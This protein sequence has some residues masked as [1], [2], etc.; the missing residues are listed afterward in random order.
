M[1]VGSSGSPRREPRRGPSSV[2]LLAK[3]SANCWRLRAGQGGRQRS[4]P[5]EEDAGDR[6]QA[7]RQLHPGILPERR[8]RQHDFGRRRAPDAAGFGAGKWDDFVANGGKRQWHARLKV[9]PRADNPLS[10]FKRAVLVTALL[11]YMWEVGGTIIT[12]CSYTSD[13]GKAECAARNHPPPI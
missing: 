13:A 7:A 3:I 11:V 5:A 8:N 4:D 9:R 10:T 12:R 2:R 6:R 1:S